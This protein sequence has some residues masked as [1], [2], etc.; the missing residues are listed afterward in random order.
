LSL[1]TLARRLSFD[2]SDLTKKGYAF[3][4]M[5]GQFTFRQ[6]NAYSKKTYLNGP[7]AYVSISGRVGLVTE[8]YNLTMRVSPYLTSS[9]P[10]IATIAG[11][12]VAGA[13]TWVI[14][15]LFSQEMRQHKAYVYKI[16]GP[17]AKPRIEEVNLHKSGN[18]SRVLH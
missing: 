11:G 2:F 3:D 18:E 10:I 8:D 16:I 1:N 12:P 5:Q 7:V 4:I 13:V 17:W 6:G 9:L 15:K 14:D